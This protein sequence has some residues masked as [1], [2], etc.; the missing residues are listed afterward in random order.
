M[1]WQGAVGGVHFLLVGPVSV[2][3]NLLQCSFCLQENGWVGA[4]AIYTLTSAETGC[5]ISM[6]KSASIP[7]PT[8]GYGWVVEIRTSRELRTTLSGLMSRNTFFCL[9]NRGTPALNFEESVS[10]RPE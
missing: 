7:C 3:P 10:L 8:S 6:G 5:I 1:C 4:S 2:S 9:R